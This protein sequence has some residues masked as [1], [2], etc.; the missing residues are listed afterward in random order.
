MKALLIKDF[1][2]LFKQMKLFIILIVV[3]AI[4]PG[5]S[6]TAFAIVYSTMIP[7]TSIAYDENCKWDRFAA[8]MPYSVR[9]LVFEKYVFGYIMAVF[10]TLISLISGFITGLVT[11]QG[12]SIENLVILV[13]YVCLA[14]ILHSLNL[15]FI[16]K[17]GVEKGRFVYL[18]FFVLL[19]V[20][21]GMFEK[22]IM[23]VIDSL[24]NIQISIVLLAV[25]LIAVTIACNIGSVLLSVRF[26]TKKIRS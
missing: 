19:F 15:P 2:T 25:A 20:V 26:Y 7:M 12:F 13:V 4:M 18:A 1:Y 14:L 16:Y 10:A 23:P 3:F 21:F 8:M 11:G 22:E 6:V 17:L 24:L 9:N 5:A